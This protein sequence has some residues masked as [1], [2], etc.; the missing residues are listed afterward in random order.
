MTGFRSIFDAPRALKT[1]V[2]VALL[3]QPRAASGPQRRRGGMPGGL[4]AGPRVA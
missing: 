4:W 1:F 2:L 3:Q